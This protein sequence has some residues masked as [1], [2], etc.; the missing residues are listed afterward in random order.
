MSIEDATWYTEGTV[1]ISC[2]APC[3]ARAFYVSV[4]ALTLVLCVCFSMSGAGCCTNIVVG[5]I[6]DQQCG[7]RRAIA[8]PGRHEVKKTF[9]GDDARQRF[10]RKIPKELLGFRIRSC[11][12]IPDP[13]NHKDDR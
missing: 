12:R 11:A 9:D 1:L 8:P 3:I 5:T 13:A 4:S 10:W 7:A 6:V 2:S